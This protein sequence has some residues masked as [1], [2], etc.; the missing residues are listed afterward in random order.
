MAAGLKNGRPLFS[1]M[2]SLLTGQQKWPPY[3]GFSLKGESE[4]HRNALK[5][6]Q[7]IPMGFLISHS[8]EIALQRFLLHQ[9]SSLC[10]A[11]LYFLIFLHMEYLACSRS[12]AILLRS[13][14]VK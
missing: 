13:K 9:L 1:G 4:A 8:D 2:D 11:L 7:C 14:P 5:G 12:S 3:G 6:F 10:E